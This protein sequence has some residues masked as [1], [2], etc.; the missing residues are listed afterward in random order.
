MIASETDALRGDILLCEGP[1]QVTYHEYVT[2]AK[3]RARQTEPAASPS[4]TTDS[5]GSPPTQV[6]QSIL[7]ADGSGDELFGLALRRGYGLDRQVS[8]SLVAWFNNC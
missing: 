2:F 6:V 3:P 4:E 8:H 5:T 7:S 1:S